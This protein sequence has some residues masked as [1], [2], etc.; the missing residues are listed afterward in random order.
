MTLSSKEK[1]TNKV[2]LYKKELS[3]LTDKDSWKKIWI[4][5]LESLAPI[6]KKGFAE[7][8]YKEDKTLFK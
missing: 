6:L 5:E 3:E 7:G 2:T 8:F 4:S 1:I